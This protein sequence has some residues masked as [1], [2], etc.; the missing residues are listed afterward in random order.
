MVCLTVTDLLGKY[1]TNNARS[2]TSYDTCLQYQYS[3][4]CLSSGV[5]EIRCFEE[6]QARG[7][8]GPLL[9]E[10]RRRREVCSK[11]DRNT[12]S[13]FIHHARAAFHN[14]VTIYSIART[15]VP[16]TQSFIIFLLANLAFVRSIHQ[17]PRV[18]CFQRLESGW[19]ETF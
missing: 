12:P 4:F 18:A 3:L 15:N 10:R 13:C 16:R 8:E 9:S 1:P 6:R 2:H 19:G 14:M 17:Q 7:D 11:Y 5:Q